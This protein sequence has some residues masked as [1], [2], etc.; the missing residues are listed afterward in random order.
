MD[1][2][3][4]LWLRL[5]TAASDTGLQLVAA[6]EVS[7]VAGAL[8]NATSQACIRLKPCLDAV[9]VYGVE[10]WKDQKDPPEN[11]ACGIDDYQKRWNM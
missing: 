6:A 8:L 10:L 7:C 3:G 9:Q 11:I 2:D 4:P 5:A 1:N